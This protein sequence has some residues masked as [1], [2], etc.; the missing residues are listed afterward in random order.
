[1]SCGD[2]AVLSHRSAAALWVLR[3]TSS[4]RIDVSLPGTSGRDARLG[5]VLHRSRRPI[6]ATAL[7]V[8]PVTTPA[9]TLADLAEVVPPRALE[10]AVE[11]AHAL[12]LLDVDAI[13]ALVAAH[14]R[15]P[16]PR[17]VQ[18][19]L[20]AH[21]LDTATRSP[22]EDAFL[23]LCDRHGIARPAVN[24]RVA[25]F[26]V[27]F[28]WPAQRLIVETDGHRHHG[29]RAAFEADRA[30]DAALTALGWR[31]VRFTDRQ[32]RH[33]AAATAALLRRLLPDLS[34]LH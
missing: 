4:P 11:Q 2:D 24:A 31:V 33:D 28:S 12:R 23:E 34:R 22:L 3:P 32:V 19:L 8:I 10:R 6:E 7:G 18:R 13:D 16:G 17:R 20:S 29:T 26:E 15:R 9:R 25:G 1:M 14:P 21:D 30:R 5:I 27:D